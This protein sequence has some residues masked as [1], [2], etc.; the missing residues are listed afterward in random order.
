[1]LAGSF[2]LLDGIGDNAGYPPVSMAAFHFGQAVSIVSNQYKG[3][4][5]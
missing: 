1:L 4:M 2:A 3:C 5:A